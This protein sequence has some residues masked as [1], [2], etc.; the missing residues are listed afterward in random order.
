VDAA[1]RY[2][3]IPY[4]VFAAEE[5]ADLDAGVPTQ[6]PFEG[7]EVDT[8]VV[9]RDDLIR[10]VAAENSH[11]I[12]MSAASRAVMKSYSYRFETPHGVIVFTGDTGPNNAVAR[13]AQ[14]ADVLV[15]EAHDS[16]QAVRR[17]N[18]TADQNHWLPKRRAGFIAHLTREALDLRAVGEMAATAHVGSVLLYHMNPADPAA[19]VAGVHAHFSGPV[20][21][22]ADL[23]RYCLMASPAERASGGE[24]FGG[25]GGRGTRPSTRP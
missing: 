22:G 6:S 21:A 20:F 19:F 16:V 10:V 8:G 18:R 4:T 14:G 7:H 23:E 2:V 24:T 17:A 5:F 3:S 12:L 1:W 11:Y 25:C 9:Y 15:A 13:L